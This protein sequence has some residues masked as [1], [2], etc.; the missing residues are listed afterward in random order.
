MRRPWRGGQV[1]LGIA[2]ILV[3]LIP[4][5]AIAFGTQQLTERYQDAVATWV[6]VH[7]MALAIV[8]VVWR[9]G[10]HRLRSPLSLLGLAP[11]AFPQ[12]KTV[13]LAGGALGA[14]LGFTVVYG[15]LV[16][17]L[18]SEI[19]SPPDITSDIAFPGAGVA[20]TFQALAL[21]TPV[22]EEIFFRGFVF[23]GLIPR[24]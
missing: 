2:L 1:A 7:V 21:V 14:S 11:L 5:T 12:A 23:S 18:D 9:L 13:L 22:T 20:L 24:L 10:V 4:V 3:A 19:L 6:S 15:V 8:V 16:G 17:F